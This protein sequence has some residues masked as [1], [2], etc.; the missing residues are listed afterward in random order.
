MLVLAIFWLIAFVGL[1]STAIILGFA[2]AC[3]EA[4]GEESIYPEGKE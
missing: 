1:V 2:N 3:G 4:A